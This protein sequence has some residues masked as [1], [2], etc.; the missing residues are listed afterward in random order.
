MN[1]VLTYLSQHWQ[2]LGL[3]TYGP[4]TEW[5][6]V[7]LTPRFHASSHVV[8]LLM[9][10]NRSQ[11][12][13]VA[14]APRLAGEGETL[15]REA[16]N[17]R[18]VQASR[19]GGFA[20]VPRVIAFEEVWQRPFLLETALVGPALDPPT[21]RRA[22]DHA[23]QAVTKWL[24]GVQLASRRSTTVDGDW[25]ERLVRKPLAS[26]QVRVASSAEDAALVD[27]TLRLAERLKELDLPL[28]VEH[29][30]LSHP[31]VMLRENGHGDDRNER[32]R[33]GV[34][35]WELA[36]LQGLP[37]CDLFFFLTYVAFALRQAR[38][39][40]RHVA[41]FHEAYF[42]P[43][44]WVTPHIKRYAQALALPPP[45]LAPLFVL[46]WARYVA[47]L[48]VRLDSAAPGGVASGQETSRWLQ[49]NRYYALWREALTHHE[50]LDAYWKS[51]L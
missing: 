33:I 19:E 20:S 25:Y 37:A 15:V 4:F 9:P 2:R 48:L 13:L 23:C 21:V 26:L 3:E 16:T 43:D 24:A 36:D 34:V 29:G 44:R 18:A 32:L 42:G 47:G 14:K 39:N 45:A 31:N 6:S 5:T 30:D 35:D 8:F 10:R 17:L 1:S 12:V 49:N 50:K 46:T 27:G 11:P 38:K 28:V 40:R 7:V 41:A 51:N 22:T